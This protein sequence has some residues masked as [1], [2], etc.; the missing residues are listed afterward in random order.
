MRAKDQRFYTAPA[1]GT[2]RHN[3]RMRCSPSFH[4]GEK[5]GGVV[6]YEGGMVELGVGVVE[7]GVGVV[8][9][10]VDLVEWV[11]LK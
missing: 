11:V 9:L 5:E 3:N 4:P 2:T 7:L 8:E 10:A 6:E 1:I